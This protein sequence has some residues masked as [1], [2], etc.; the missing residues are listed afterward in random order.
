[1]MTLYMVFEALRDRR[2]RL[3]Q[4][5]PVSAHAAS[6]APS[7]LGIV[8]GT[9]LTV[10]EA[11]LALVTKSANDVAAALGEL[12]GGGE[13]RFAQMMTLRARA[14]GMSRTVFRNASGLPDPNQWTTARDIATLGR[15]L[16]RDF[17]AEYRY[18]STPSFR[19][20]GRTIFS[21]DH[22]LETYPGA[23]GIKTG[24]TDASGYNLVTSAVRGGVR[25][26]GAVF[27]AARAPERDLHMTALLNQAFERL[28]IGAPQH[29]TRTA[30]LIPSAQAAEPPRLRGGRWA[31]QVGAFANEASARN[32][33]AA[34]RRYA[35][36][37]EPRV[38]ATNV[39]G[40][41]LWRA[42]LVGFAGREAHDICA[43]ITRHRLRCTPVRL[44][45][46][47]LASR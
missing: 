41:P 31:V 27:G 5:V 4:L 29:T 11:I 42:Q 32:V 12:L 7:K 14:L 34:A 6:M 8:P 24:Y 46:G 18:F 47:E 38:E 44:D 9:R 16:V 35:G 15:H 20:H 25:L 1:M 26:V 39:R 30:S 45:Q 40:M 19:F 21:H 36:A 10:R 2:I 13:Q 33:A 37:G 22:M 3:D 17:P 23:D 28:D 43:S